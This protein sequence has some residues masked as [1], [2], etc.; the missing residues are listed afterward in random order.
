MQGEGTRDVAAR[1]ARETRQHN[2]E[3]DHDRIDTTMR[4]LYELHLPHRMG[5]PTTLPG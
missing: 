1:H 5:L 2:G 3:D 4:E